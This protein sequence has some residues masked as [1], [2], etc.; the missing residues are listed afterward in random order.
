MIESVFSV[1]NLWTVLVAVAIGVGAIFRKAILEFIVSKIG[2]ANSYRLEI[3]K[4]EQRIRE[5]LKRDLNLSISDFHKKINGDLSLK[6]MEAAE[7]LLRARRTLAQF[8]ILTQYMQILD[9]SALIKQPN[10]EVRRL[11]EE[12]VKPYDGKLSQLQLDK[13]KAELYLNNKT[14]QAYEIYEHLILPFRY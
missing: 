4:A 2:L 1:P 9:I 13:A 8:H 3:S 7:E 14:I 12:L 6:K 10:S 5:N 11:V